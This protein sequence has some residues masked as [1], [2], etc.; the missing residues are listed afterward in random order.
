MTVI[1]AIATRHRSA[2]TPDAKQPAR[3]AIDIID[4]YLAA[5]PGQTGNVLARLDARR[6]RLQA[7]VAAT[8]REPRRALR[9][10]RLRPVSRSA[11]VAEC[12]SST[13][14]AIPTASRTSYV[15]SS[16]GTRTVARTGTLSARIA[17]ASDLR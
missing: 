11:Q 9:M 12:G 16:G 5:H 17:P 2:P 4:A 7:Q 15:S 1:D 8:P 14:P 13:S 10:M 6:T 3:D